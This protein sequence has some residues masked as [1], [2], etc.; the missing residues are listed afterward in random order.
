MVVGRDCWL[1]DITPNERV[2]AVTHQTCLVLWTWRKLAD[3]T[4]VKNCQNQ[5]SLTILL[6]GPGVQGTNEEVSPDTSMCYL[7]QRVKSRSYGRSPG[8]GEALGVSPG[9]AE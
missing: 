9:F 1:E 4:N 5:F 2:R 6:G 8:T 7:V 3:E